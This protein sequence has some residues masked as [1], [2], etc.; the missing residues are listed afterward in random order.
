MALSVLLVDDDPAFRLLARRL[1]AAIGLAV[2]AEADTA[3]GAMTVAARLEPEAA[4]VDVGLPD[5]DG[6]SLARRLVDLPWQPR[7]VVCSVDADAASADDVQRSGARAFIHKA[8]LPD[9]PLRM[10][11]TGG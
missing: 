1:L 10:L 9:A 5:D 7:V 6:L 2:I 3:A 8:D 4:L 11:L